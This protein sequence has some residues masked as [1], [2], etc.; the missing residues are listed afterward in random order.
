MYEIDIL[1]YL[2]KDIAKNETLEKISGLIDKS[3]LKNENM[4]KYHKKNQ[5]KSYTFNSFYPLEKNFY[6]EGGLYQVKIRVLGSKLYNYL[7]SA[8]P[9]TRTQYLQLL[10]VKMNKLRK[11][12]IIKLYS[13]TPAIC[14]S[15]NGYWKSHYGIDEY[16]KFITKNA[17]KKYNQFYKE[18]LTENFDFI[19]K[20]EFTNRIPIGNKYKNITFLGDKIELEIEDNPIAQNLAWIIYTTGVLEMGARGYGYMNAK[21]LKL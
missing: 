5:Y 1:V 4:K 15:D 18:N 21:Y 16:E 14:K 2:L 3:F 6:K 17:I 9:G 10:T 7:K 8:L 11:N 12:H 13:I 20:I 19:R